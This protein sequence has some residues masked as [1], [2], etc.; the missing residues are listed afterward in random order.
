[1]TQ[2]VVGIPVKGIVQAAPQAFSNGDEAPLPI[3]TTGAVKVVGALAGGLIGVQLNA[4][5]K[6]TYR[7]NLAGVATIIGQTIEIVGSGSKTVNIITVFLSK[8]S[9]QV[10]V[11]VTRQTVK[12]TVGAKTNPTPTPMATSAGAATATVNLYT[13]APV[14]GTSA[15]IVFQDQVSPADRIAD[16]PG[17]RTGQ[18]CVVSGVAESVAISFDAVATING[19]YIEWTEV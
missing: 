18:P 5:V 8:P 12:S 7:Y 19:G 16:E 2:T 10:N 13:V 14:A 15:G 11:T 9:V 3:D 4:P 6:N 1:M 17:S